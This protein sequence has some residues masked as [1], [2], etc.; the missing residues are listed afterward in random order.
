VIS[1]FPVEQGYKYLKDQIASEEEQSSLYPRKPTSLNRAITLEYHP[2]IDFDTKFPITMT[3]RSSGFIG[4]DQGIPAQ[5]KAIQYNDMLLGPFR[6]CG[7]L[8]KVSGISKAGR[9]T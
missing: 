7:A 2:I 3:N 6:I 1:G 5:M 8:V 4:G 9:S